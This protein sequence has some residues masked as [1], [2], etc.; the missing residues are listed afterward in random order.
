MGEGGRESLRSTFRSGHRTK[1]FDLPALYALHRH[2]LKGSFQ[3]NTRDEKRSCFQAGVATQMDTA[4]ILAN[5]RN[6]SGHAAISVDM[7]F[8]RS[9]TLHDG[10]DCGTGMAARG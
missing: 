8:S 6:M 1:D 3:T 2:R 4:V 9:S 7:Q 10:E 5:S